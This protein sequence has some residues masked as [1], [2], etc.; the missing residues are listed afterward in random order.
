[1]RIDQYPPSTPVG[2]QS[3]IIELDN[4]NRQLRVNREIIRKET[5]A[6]FN[7]AELFFMAHFG[8]SPFEKIIK[9][10]LYDPVGKYKGIKPGTLDVRKV[11]A[12]VIKYS[13]PSPP[14]HMRIE[15]MTLI[16]NGMVKY[17]DTTVQIKKNEAEIIKLGM[18]SLLR[19]EAPLPIQMAAIGEAK[20]LPKTFDLGNKSADPTQWD[21][22]HNAVLQDLAPYLYRGADAW[23]GKISDA[24]VLQKQI[25]KLSDELT[26]YNLTKWGSNYYNPTD[27]KNASGILLT[28]FLIYHMKS[29]VGVQ[30]PIGYWS[31]IARYRL[32]AVAT[33]P[34][35]SDVFLVEVNPTTGAPYKR[36]KLVAKINATPSDALAIVARHYPNVLELQSDVN[37]SLDKEVNI[38]YTTSKLNESAQNWKATGN[39]DDRFFVNIVET[40]WMWPDV[41]LAVDANWHNAFSSRKATP[42]QTTREQRHLLRFQSAN[43]TER[44]DSLLKGNPPA[45]VQ[46]LLYGGTTN[47]MRNTFPVSVSKFYLMPAGIERALELICVDTADNVVAKYVKTQLGTSMKEGTKYAYL[48]NE[49]EKQFNSKINVIKGVM[50]CLG[51]VLTSPFLLSKG[52]EYALAFGSTERTGYSHSTTVRGEVKKIFRAAKWPTSAPSLLFEA[53]TN[54]RVD[55]Q[56]MRGKF[57][58]V[59]A[60]TGGKA[61]PE[62]SSP[63]MPFMKI[64]SAPHIENG[65]QKMTW[66][67]APGIGHPFNAGT[68]KPDRGFLRYYTDGRQWNTAFLYRDLSFA[69]GIN[70]RN[71]IRSDTALT[72][73]SEIYGE[74]EEVGLSATSRNEASN[75]EIAIGGT[76]LTAVAGAAVIAAMYSD[77]ARR[78]MR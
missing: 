54:D 2:N 48:V 77:S 61:P 76:I 17:E 35:N 5:D 78:G 52:Y 8:M 70:T 55:L 12:E 21:S 38:S 74:P 51:A 10:F 60:S 24:A 50:K 57:E 49:T 25:Q 43:S 68:M 36:G 41:D 56:N 9:D 71:K 73:Y 6:K 34:N 37:P 31:H 3:R 64:Q 44:R 20:I 72:T 4:A 1:M 22:R 45:S 62:L 40:N 33:G 65:L 28:P 59:M 26:K 39:K 69:R 11:A 53:P 27:Y 42:G 63:E 66:Q 16:I 75:T 32:A 13:D 30:G 19:M 14:Q 58:K 46:H 18:D 29:I 15:K 67:L 7:S 47:Q 23:I